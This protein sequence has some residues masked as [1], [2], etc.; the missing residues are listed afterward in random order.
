VHQPRSL[1]HRADRV[2]A[3]PEPPPPPPK[4]AARRPLYKRGWFWG[5]VAALTAVAVGA[6]VLTSGADSP[7]TDL[8][9]VDFD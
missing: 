8:G 3:E 2:R 6:V 9:N 1:V 7:S 5:G 4:P